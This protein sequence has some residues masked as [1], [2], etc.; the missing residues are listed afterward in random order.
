MKLTLDKQNIPAHVSRVTETLKNAGFEAY[1][2]GG[3]VRDLIMKHSPKDWDITTNALPE[4]IIG[5]FEAPSTTTLKVVYEN[6]FGTVALVDEL[7]PLD[8]PVRQIEVTPYRSES[9]YSD[10]RHPDKITFSETL[11]EDLKRRDFTMN[12]LAYDIENDTLTDL[13]N[14]IKDISDK[15]IR[16]VGDSTTRLSEDALRIIRAIRFSSQLGFMVSHE[17]MD[18]LFHVKHLINNVSRERIRDEFV[19]LINSKSP[20]IGITLM[21]QLGILELIIP[22]LME[23]VD[24]H[25]GGAHKYDVFEHL[26]HACQHAADKNYPFH[27]KLAALF[28]DIGKPRSKRQG[29]IKPTF[30]GH[31]VIG[32]RMAEQIMDRLKFPKSDTEIVVKLVRYHMFFS[33]TEQITLSAVRRMIQNIS[34]LSPEALSKLA[35]ELPIWTLMKIRECDRVGMAKA[36]APFR[37][38]KYHAMIDQ[39]LRDPIS[40]SQLAID[41]NYLMNEL[42][43][44]PGRRM[45]WILHALLEEVLEKPENNT[46][47]ALSLHVKQLET[48]SDDELKDLGEKAKQV[49]EEQ[50]QQEITQ[51][52]VKHGVAN[53]KPTK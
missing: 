47:E 7:E 50:E 49:K 48:L 1:I 36:E 30:Y 43:V 12:A 6:N 13:F 22:E 28:H 35:P 5:L 25:Q 23:G 34:N 26:L 2:V 37:L 39:C 32:A 11:E 17:T 8:S 20:I 19:K 33:D 45:G 44:K 24:C 38:R 3:C 40:V 15:T 42:H 21:K 52:H 29:K 46:V 9:G 51:L 16:C 14:G 31:E 41:G 18:A 4:Q 27:V 53:K 10:N